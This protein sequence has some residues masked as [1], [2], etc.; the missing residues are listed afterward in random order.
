MRAQTVASEME[1]ADVSASLG[2]QEV[3]ELGDLLA[4]S[5]GVAD[6]TA[7]VQQGSG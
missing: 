3:D 7:V 5:H 2:H 1:T 6:G 4:N